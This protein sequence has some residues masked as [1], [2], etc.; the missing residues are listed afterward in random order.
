MKRFATSE[1]LLGFVA[2]ALALVAL[3]I[4]VPLDI[5]TGLVEKV[6]RQVRIG[7]AML[8][9]VALSFVIIGG[10]MTA[11]AQQADAARM[12]RHNLIFLAKLVLTLT[13]SLLIMRWLG[14]LAVDLLGTDGDYRALRDERPWKYIGFIA[15]GMTLV[16]GLIALME[17]R[18]SLRGVIIGLC[19]A[20]ALIAIYDLPFEDL[21][22]PPNG[23]V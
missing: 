13:V 23:D 8:P 22:L 1:G 7:D 20:L 14:P 10:L 17:G 19:A 18:F 5:E 9:I 16:V 15:G 11:F 12:Q 2:I 3:L 6:R 21:L 4:W